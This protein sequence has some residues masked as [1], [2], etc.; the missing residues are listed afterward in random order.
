[1]Y[2]NKRWTMILQPSEFRSNHVRTDRP[3]I[4]HWSAHNMLAAVAILLTALQSI[5]TPATSSEAPALRMV[6]IP[7]P[8]TSIVRSGGIHAELSL[9]LEAVA[10]IEELTDKVDLPLWRLR[11]LPPEQRNDQAEQLIGQLK[12]RLSEILS[13]QQMERLNQIVWQAQGVEAIL[14]PEVA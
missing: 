8:I 9:P 10:L 12:R 6:P 4:E 5:G 3:I 14:E 7:H 13:V 1:M 2:V 11:D